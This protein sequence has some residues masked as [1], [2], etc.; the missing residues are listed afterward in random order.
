[1]GSRLRS[2]QEFTGLVVY[3]GADSSRP[4]SHT[5]GNLAKSA[6]PASPTGQCFGSRGALAVLEF[7]IHPVAGTLVDRGGRSLLLGGQGGPL[8]LGYNEATEASSDAR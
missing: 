3:V 7:L 4:F 1:M 5:S 2:L 6:F 8:A